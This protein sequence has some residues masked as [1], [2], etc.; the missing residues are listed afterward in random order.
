MFSKMIVGYTLHST[1]YTQHSKIYILYPRRSSPSR[2]L[3]IEGSLKSSKEDRGG[4]WDKTKNEDEV[5]G[6]IPGQRGIHEAQG[7]GRGIFPLFDHLS[8]LVP[9]GPSDLLAR[10]PSSHLWSPC[11][12][13]FFLFVTHNPFNAV[14]DLPILV[15]SPRIL[16]GSGSEGDDVLKNM[17]IIS[18]CLP[19]GFVAPFPIPLFL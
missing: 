3:L 4:D 6:Q 19:P 9:F 1:P 13:A 5:R 18:I 7:V 11:F 12:G 15:I 10:W 16:L 17:G 2:S 8:F 14:V